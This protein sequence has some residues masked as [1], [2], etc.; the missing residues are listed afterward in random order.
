MIEIIIKR[1]D[2]AAGIAA[3]FAQLAMHGQHAAVAR[4][5]VQVV[6]VLRDQ[7]EIIAQMFF[8]IRQRQMRGIGIDTSAHQLPPPFII[9]PVNRG[10]VAHEALRGGNVFDTVTFPQPVRA[11][12]GA[13]ARF[14][15]YPR[16]CQNHH[17]HACNP[18][19]AAAQWPRHRKIFTAQE[20]N[21]LWPVAKIAL[22]ACIIAFAS[23]LSGKRPE[24]A[25]F[26]IALP[27]MSLLAL[28]FSHAEFKDAEASIRFAKSIVMAVP[29]SL[30]F[31]VPFLLAQRLNMGF[32]ALY[33][34]GVA[35]LVAAYFIHSWVMK[36]IA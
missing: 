8:K 35:L 10:G 31:F 27:L 36:H 22:S 9:K 16:P 20:Y 24:L 33:G 15:R 7:Q 4:A 28:A 34:T 25:G 3:R 13:N 23:W 18:F 19:R 6:N 14:R 30:M 2:G 21:M 29:L 32:W 17:A 1:R 11:A 5:L 12:K 26:I